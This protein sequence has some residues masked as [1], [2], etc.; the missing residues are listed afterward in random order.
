MTEDK[1]TRDQR[2]QA[3]FEAMTE[4]DGIHCPICGKGLVRTVAH[5]PNSNGITVA[6]LDCPNQCALAAGEP[7][8]E[9]E[10]ER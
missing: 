5:F 1:D 8:S 6:H 4:P 3:L 10:S 7:N 2:I 9:G